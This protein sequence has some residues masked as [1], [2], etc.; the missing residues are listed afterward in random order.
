MNI[1]WKTILYCIIVAA[2]SVLLYNVIAHSF[3]KAKTLVGIKV[4][5]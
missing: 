4:F 1:D 5:V 2:I 3:K